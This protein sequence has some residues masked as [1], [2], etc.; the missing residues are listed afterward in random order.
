MVSQAG[1]GFCFNT[2]R[3]RLKE[4]L[5]LLHYD[6]VESRSVA[7]A[8]VQRHDLGSLQ[9][10]PPG[11]TPFCCLSL[12]SSWDYRHLPPCLAN[13]FFFCIFNRDGVSPCL[14]GWSRSPDLVILPPQPPKV[15]GL[16][17]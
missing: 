8:R 12:L 11:F 15:L 10:P 16:Q 4:K 9:A 13:F 17:A 1:T 6:P 2:K 14:P 7:Q 3:N 5:T